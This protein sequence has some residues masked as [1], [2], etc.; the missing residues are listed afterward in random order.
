MGRAF[1]RFRKLSEDET[2]EENADEADDFVEEPHIMMSE[3]ILSK[4][5]K[6]VVRS[7]M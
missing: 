6:L 7:S 5:W 4:H 3:E 2:K 1:S